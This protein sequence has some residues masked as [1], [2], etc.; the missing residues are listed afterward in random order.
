MRAVA[1]VVEAGL[2][3]AGSPACLQLRGGEFPVGAVFGLHQ[4]GIDAQ[5]AGGVAEHRMRQVKAGID[6]TDDDARAAICDLPGGRQADDAVE[7]SLLQHGFLLFLRFDEADV[8]CVINSAAEAHGHHGRPQPATEILDLACLCVIEDGG[9]VFARHGFD[10]DRDHRIRWRRG[11]ARYRK[12][13]DDRE[14][15][16]AIRRILHDLQRDRGTG[17]NLTW[18]HGVSPLCL[19]IS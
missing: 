10:D 3:A 5:S 11:L 6:D 8:G 1:M 14:H 19:K 16:L 13:P 15:A 17:R 7:Q 2:V 9:D 18:G 12:R 4:Q